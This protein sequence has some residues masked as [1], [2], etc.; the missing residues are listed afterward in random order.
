[1]EAHQLL[2][3]VRSFAAEVGWRVLYVWVILLVSIFFL[4]GFFFYEKMKGDDAVMPIRL[5][6]KEV[7]A[8][9]LSLW[10]GWMR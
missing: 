9:C 7:V 2:S 3:S 1:M 8:V 6:T 5:F 4:V 10:W